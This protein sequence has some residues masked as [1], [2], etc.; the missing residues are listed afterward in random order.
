MTL[1]IKIGVQMLIVTLHVQ[2]IE[3]LKKNIDFE[4]YIVKLDFAD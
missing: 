3:Y 2:T 1:Q 4:K